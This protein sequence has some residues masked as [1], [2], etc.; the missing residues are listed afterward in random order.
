MLGFGLALAQ[1]V[2]VACFHLNGSS[3]WRIPFAI[4]C[5]PPAM[6][7]VLIWTVPESPRW[8]MCILRTNL[9]KGA[10]FIDY[11]LVYSHGRRD[12]A[13]D[14]LIK[15]HKSPHDPTNSYALGE[16]QIMGAQL[17][18]ELETP[19]TIW[20]GFKKPSIRKRFILGIVSQSG[21]QLSGMLTILSESGPFHFLFL[22]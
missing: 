15:L 2:G 17:Q 6:L 8:C 19:A 5:V 16:F 13:L 3:G 20:Q 9:S 7:A 1:W 10:S 4:N 14:V 22:L 21:T 18:L 12:E 11:N